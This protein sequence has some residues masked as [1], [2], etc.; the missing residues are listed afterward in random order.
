MCYVF[1]TNDPLSPKPFRK[2]YIGKM[3][4]SKK[5]TFLPLSWCESGSR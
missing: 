5:N 2:P 3:F 1:L 4:N